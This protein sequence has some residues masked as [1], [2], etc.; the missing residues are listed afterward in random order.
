MDSQSTL[1]L[2]MVDGHNSYSTEPSPMND[3]YAMVVLPQTLWLR[4]LQEGKGK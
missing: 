2:R 3:H 4:R 1:V